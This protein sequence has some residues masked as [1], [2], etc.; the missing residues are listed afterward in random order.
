MTGSLSP[1][2]VVSDI[3]KSASFYKAALDL[4]EE[5]RVDTPEGPAF[6]MLGRDGFRLMLEPIRTQPPEMKAL[7]SEGPRATLTL[8]LSIEKLDAEIRRLERA[9]V[10]FEG[11][12]TRPYGMKEVSFK[13][14]DGYFWTIG[15]RVGE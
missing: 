3:A 15:E 2:L 5:D 13:D 1:D 12:V 4:V 6:F 9:G 11:P 7:L 8:Y 10:S 14:P